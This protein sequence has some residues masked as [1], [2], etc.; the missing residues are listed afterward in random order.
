MNLPYASLED[1]VAWAEGIV[2]SRDPDF[3]IGANY[4]RRWWLIPRNELQNLYLHEIN[5]SDDDRA[6]HDHPWENTSV[7][8]RGS[9]T[10]HTPEGVFVRQP[11]DA[12][13]RPATTMHRLEVENNARVL[14]LFF[15]GPKIREW[16]FDCPQG[17]R[18]WRDF[19][20]EERGVGDTFNSV[21]GR[22]CGEG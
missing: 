13:Y 17:W 16:G 9:Y 1:L 18:H 2:V 10:E 11:G 6:F 4:L 19:T 7:I 20:R 5:K 8:L 12:I 15:T 22:G 21:T 14:S 3:V